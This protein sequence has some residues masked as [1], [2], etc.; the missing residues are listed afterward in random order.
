M[1][2]AAVIHMRVKRVFAFLRDRK[3]FSAD[4]AIPLSEVPYSDKWYIR[5]LVKREVIK[6]HE[7]NCY[8][9]E[10]AVQL[11]LKRRRIRIF[12]FVGVVLL[13]MFLYLLF[14]SFIR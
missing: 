10:T 13:M 12:A 3:A 4:T 14:I 11:Y 6:V 8:L 2:A 7:G 5:R 9:D 1:S